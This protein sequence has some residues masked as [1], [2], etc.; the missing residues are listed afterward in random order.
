MNSKTGS[1]SYLGKLNNQYNNASSSRHSLL[2]LA[3]HT[4]SITLP[5]SRQSRLKCPRAVRI[6]VTTR[7]SS[8]NPRNNSPPPQQRI[9]KT[10][11]W[12]YHWRRPLWIS[13]RAWFHLKLGWLLRQ[14]LT[15]AR[16]NKATSRTNPRKLCRFSTLLLTWD[17]NP[18]TWR[19]STLLNHQLASYLRISTWLLLK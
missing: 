17:L 9:K 3:T 12:I 18:S 11:L 14:R 2:R 13:K 10:S 16:L 7:T 6:S 4:L 19:P 8:T 15:L 1:A 5:A